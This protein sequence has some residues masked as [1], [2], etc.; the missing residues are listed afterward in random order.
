MRGIVIG[1]SCFP[2]GFDGV[3]CP[4]DHCISFGIFVTMFL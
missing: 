2:G 1:G 3:G 4:M